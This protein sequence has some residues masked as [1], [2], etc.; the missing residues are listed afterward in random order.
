H[1]P[2]QQTRRIGARK[3][4][5]SQARWIDH[6]ARHFLFRFPR[7]PAAARK[8][9]LA[10]DDKLNSDHA[11]LIL[12]ENRP[13]FFPHLVR[14]PICTKNQKQPTNCSSRIKR[15][16]I[17]QLFTLPPLSPPPSAPL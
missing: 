10:F 11:A 13:R 16:H 9:H 3:A 8:P 5:R 6:S 7:I 2:L 17:I 1:E 4:Y 14:P 15:V 12:F